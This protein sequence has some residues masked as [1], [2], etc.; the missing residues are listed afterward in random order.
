MSVDS[1]LAV[2]SSVLS[3]L[4]ARVILNY[5]STVLLVDR[6]LLTRLDSLLIFTV[7]CMITAQV[8]SIQLVCNYIFCIRMLA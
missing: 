2:I 3:I 5:F 7:G 6:N 1:F 8:L 4:T